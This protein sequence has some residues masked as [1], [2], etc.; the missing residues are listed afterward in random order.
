MLKFIIKRL[1]LSAV[2]LFFVMFLIYTVM[3]SLPSSYVETM[4]RE[5]AT[6]PGS[7]KSAAQWLAELNAQYGMDKNVF[8]GFLTWLGQAIQ[9]NLCL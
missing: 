4:A 2:I 9:G 8:E 7:Q 1:L 5:L 6:K 3:Y